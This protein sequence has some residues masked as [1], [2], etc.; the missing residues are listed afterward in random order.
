MAQEVA[1]ALIEVDGEAV[2]VVG[3][4]GPGG[5]DV[6]DP[7][8]QDQLSGRVGPDQ[9][10]G[11]THHHHLTLTRRRLLIVRLRVLTR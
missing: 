9:P 7:C 8:D 6:F 2:E 5:G 4:V 3:A 10:A 1:E 11:L